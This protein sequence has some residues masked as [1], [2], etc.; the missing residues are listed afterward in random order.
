[1]A[2]NAYNLRRF[3]WSIYATLTVCGFRWQ[4]LFWIVD[5]TLETQVNVNKF[6]LCGNLRIVTAD[7]VLAMRPCPINWHYSTCVLSFSV[8]LSLLLSKSPLKLLD[9]FEPNV[10]GIILIWT[11]L[12][13]FKWLQSVAYLGQIGLKYIFKMKYHNDY[14]LDIWYVAKFSRPL[15]SLLK[16]WPCG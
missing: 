5:T 4:K 2:C 10:A 11:S 12:I 15:Q 16:L 8:L 1:M 9:G 14:N 7:T 6:I 3:K 13:V